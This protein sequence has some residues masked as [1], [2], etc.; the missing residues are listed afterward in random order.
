ML[1]FDLEVAGDRF[2]SSD[3]ISSTSIGLTG[4]LA[5]SG[6]GGQAFVVTSA[7]AGLL[8]LLSEASSRSISGDKRSGS[9]CSI[10]LS[11]EMDSSSN[12]FVG[13]SWVTFRDDSF[14]YVMLGE[15]VFVVNV[16]RSLL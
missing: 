15:I 2:Q 12:I 4:L 8:L 6:D 7:G 10:E 5:D 3:S 1:S 16:S 11:G 9:S 14:E 13:N